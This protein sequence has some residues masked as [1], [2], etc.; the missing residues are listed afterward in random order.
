MKF[1]Q[2]KVQAPKTSEGYS[3]IGFEFPTKDVHT[4]EKIEFHKQ[5]REMIYSTVTQKVLSVQK[6]QNS[7][8][9]V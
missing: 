4:I 9:N 5:A 8:A 1:L 3:K 7:L 6:L 2:L